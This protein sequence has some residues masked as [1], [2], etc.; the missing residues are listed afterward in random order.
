MWCGLIALGAGATSVATGLGGVWVSDAAGDR[1]FRVDPQTDQVTA[2]INV[3]TGPTGLA[4][5]FG[6][7]WVA[8]SLDGT[9]SRIDPQTN[10]VTATVDVGDGAGAVAVGDGGV[11]VSSQYAGNVSRIDPGSDAVTHDGSSRQPPPGAGGR[12]RLGLGRAC[13]PPARA[14]A[15]AR[16]SVLTTGYVDTFDPVLTQNLGE[17]CR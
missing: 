7:V 12:G 2:V 16:C 11:W 15:A 13:G 10:T 5:G 9:V 14:I 6:S 17:S 4:V 1:V 8:N 3:G